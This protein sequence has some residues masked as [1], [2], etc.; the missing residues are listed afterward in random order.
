ML[1]GN[2]RKSIAVGGA[3]ALP[4]MRHDGPLPHRPVIAVEVWNIPP[5]WPA[6]LAAAYGDV[7]NDPAAWARKVVEDGADLVCVRLAG[8]DPEAEDASPAACADAVRAVLAAVNVPV[9][10]LGCGDDEKDNLVFPTVC[11]AAEGTRCLVGPVHKDNYRTIAAAA[12][13]AGHA[14]IAQSPVDVNIQKQVA[15]LLEEMELGPQ[16]IVFDPTTGTLGYGLDYTYSVMERIRLAALQGDRHL[17]SPMM[18]FP[19]YETW[20]VK[21]AGLAENAA[22]G[23]IWEIVTATALLH[24]G[25]DILVLLHPEAVRAVRGYLQEMLGEAAA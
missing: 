5:V 16:D 6:S 1:G 24:A 21:E 8:A 4:F 14:V 7:L 10:I 3:G 9:I 18:V 25:A 19:G 23:I 13:V 11:T 17:S 20:K 15:V 22:Q 2:G 12:K